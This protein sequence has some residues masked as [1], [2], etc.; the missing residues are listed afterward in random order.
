MSQRITE[1][2]RKM[3]EYFLNWNTH[4]NWK[5]ENATAEDNECLKALV[6]NGSGWERTMKIVICCPYR[7]ELAK[8][9]LINAPDCIDFSEIITKYNRLDL[10]MLYYEIY[11]N[12]DLNWISLIAIKKGCTDTFKWVVEKLF[13]KYDLE[14]FNQKIFHIMQQIMKKGNT[15]MFM[16]LDRSFL[17]STVDV[18]R[19]IRNSHWD[20][21]ELIVKSECQIVVTIEYLTEEQIEKSREILEKSNNVVTT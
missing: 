9:L 21:L 17:L 13:K 7:V 19:A 15:T 8:W 4:N 6:E 18:T 1:A 20:L 3:T 5:A 12:V 11:P 14:I 10:V 16:W 2:M